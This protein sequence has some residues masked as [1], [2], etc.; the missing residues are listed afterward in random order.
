MICASCNRAI[1]PGEPSQEY[2]ITSGTGAVPSVHFH[3]ECPVR[4][5]YVRRYP[6]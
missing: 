2:V 1:L 6:V 4:R 3:V 5:P